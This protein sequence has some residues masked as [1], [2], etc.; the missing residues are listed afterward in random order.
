MEAST[1]TICNHAC[2]PEH[3]TKPR[4]LPAS[5]YKPTPNRKPH[6][7]THTHAHTHTRTHTHTHTHTQAPAAAPQPDPALVAGLVDMG[8]GEAACARAAAAVSNAG[9]EAAMEWLLAHLEDPDIN[10]PLPGGMGLGGGRDC[11]RK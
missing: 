9:L 3:V 5:L 1:R 7:H 2:P 11:C 6:T 10:D 8:F 4:V